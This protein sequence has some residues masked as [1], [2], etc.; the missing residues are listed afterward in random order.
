M[1]RTRWYKVINDLWSHRT[2]TL[3]VSLAVAVGVYA[4]GSILATQ[5]LMLREFHSDRAEA[6]LAHAIIY[7]QP[8]DAELAERVAEQPGIA[9][10]EGRE[11]FRSRVV[12]DPDTRRNIQIISV[13]DF[14]A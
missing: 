13:N 8:F 2:R 6:R 9:A 5:T 7:T 11:S 1:L 10:A 12:I 3:I 14:D 4:V